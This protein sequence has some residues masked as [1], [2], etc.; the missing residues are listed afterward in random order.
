MQP[1]GVRAADAAEPA[2]GPVSAAGRALCRLGAL[3]VASPGLQCTDCTVTWVYGATFPSGPDGRCL[4][5]P[6]S[7]SNRKPE[8]YKGKGVRYVDEVIRCA[9]PAA[10]GAAPLVAAA[11][12]SMTPRQTSDVQGLSLPA[13]ALAYDVCLAALQE[14]GGQAWQVGMLR[15]AFPA[16]RSPTAAT[17]AVCQGPSTSPGQPAAVVDAAAARPVLASVLA[18]SRLAAAW[19]PH[20]SY[21]CPNIQ[22]SRENLQFWAMTPPFSVCQALLSIAVL[23]VF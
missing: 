21:L 15:R 6:L 22:A 3:V 1:R 11:D 16:R 2:P 13:A 5:V 10:A 14:E 18:S 23:P 17:G 12:A 20:G 7:R 19:R 4:P 8:P 9:S